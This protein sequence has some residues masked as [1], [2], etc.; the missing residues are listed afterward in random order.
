[1][2]GGFEDV[3]LTLDGELSDRCGV[4]G[5]R[6]PLDP[7]S[8]RKIQQ[9]VESLKR[10]NSRQWITDVIIM[11]CDVFAIGRLSRTLCE[12]DAQAADLV[13]QCSAAL[14]DNNAQLRAAH[15]LASELSGV[16]ECLK[17]DAQKKA[18]LITELKVE[19]D[20]LN[21]RLEAALDEIYRTTGNSTC[22]VRERLPMMPTSPQCP[23][24]FS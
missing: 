4:R 8:Y 21:G 22:T 6:M 11:P 1:M 23:G 18:D 14:Q 5:Y 9:E 13:A 10:E 20:L 19:K 3:D 12:M 7:A 15:Q 2:L 17:E 16:V 24:D